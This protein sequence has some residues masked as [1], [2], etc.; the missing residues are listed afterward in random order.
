MRRLVIITLLIT[1]LLS[2]MVVSCQQQLETVPPTAMPTSVPTPAAIPAQF[3]V[4]SVDIKPPEIMSGE[5]AN[6]S[7]QIENI[8]DGE[9]AYIAILLVDDVEIKRKVVT[10]KPKATEV[11]AFTI[12]LYQDGSHT[13]TLGELSK[14]CIIKKTIAGITKINSIPD[15]L[16]TDSDYGG[17]PGGGCYW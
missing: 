11:V 15:Y 1:S 14:E 3:K 8:G 17:L 13:I 9:G 7:A 2:V 4:I 6:I 5:T 16:Q 10:I 12:I